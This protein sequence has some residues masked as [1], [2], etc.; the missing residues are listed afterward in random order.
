MSLFP[1][2]YEVVRAGSAQAATVDNAEALLGLRTELE[3]MV[4]FGEGATSDEIATLDEQLRTFSGESSEDLARQDSLADMRT[5]LADALDP[6]NARAIQVIDEEFPQIK[7]AMD[8]GSIKKEKRR[9]RK[10]VE[11]QLGIVHA[12]DGADHAGQSMAGADGNAASSVPSPTDIPSN[13]DAALAEADDLIN[14]LLTSEP[15]AAPVTGETAAVLS[16][17]TKLLEEAAAA[18]EPP[19]DLASA[20]EAEYSPDNPDPSAI[21]T[22]MEQ[23]AVEAD[24]VQS[25]R[26]E[27]DLV[28]SS[29]DTTAEMLIAAQGDMNDIA[30]SLEAAVDGLAELSEAV[31]HS[32]PPTPPEEPQE[33]ATEIENSADLDSCPD[34]ANDDTA[35]EAMA[36]E[37]EAAVNAPESPS[38]DAES[39]AEIH[40][41]SELTDTAEPD[42]VAE[43]MGTPAEPDDSTM[44]AEVASE[45]SEEPATVEAADTP[46]SEEAA[47]PALESFAP[48]LAGCNVTDMRRQLE[49]VKSILTSQIDRLGDLVERSA[50]MHET[51]RRTAEQAARFR[52]AANQASEASRRF[53]TAQAAAE[54]ARAAYEAAQALAAE[55]RREWEAAQ[56]AAVDAADRIDSVTC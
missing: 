6:A 40:L 16:E 14:E 52:V 18:P 10:E 4:Q 33:A 45:V 56:Q 48:P 46:K 2:T 3:L 31:R 27:E 26:I 30:E 19:V 43:L 37:L 7:E 15:G 17:S 1:K 50:A 47:R 29:P 44:V 21:T 5:I 51:V 32:P 24:S 36:A 12:A 41:L 38:E 9:F 54:Q 28:A 20:G 39:A 55:T 8:M 25:I 13:V 11:Q 34:A 53:A 23:L 49:D 42:L 22:L 35:F